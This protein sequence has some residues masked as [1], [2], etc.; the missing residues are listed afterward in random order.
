MSPWP[1]RTLRALGILQMVFAILGLW[2]NASGIISLLSSVQT[3]PRQPYFWHAYCAMSA[4]CVTCYVTLLVIAVEFIRLRPRLAPLFV[5]IMVFEVVYFFGIGVFWTSPRLGMSIEAA[6]GV[7]NGG[8]M[9][10]F[11]ALF[12]LW[13]SLLALWSRRRIEE[14]PMSPWELRFPSEQIARPSDWVYAGV[15][16]VVMFFLVSMVV[17]FAWRQMRPGTFTPGYVRVGV[18]AVISVVNALLAVRQRRRKRRRRIE[19]RHAAR[20]GAGLC[21]R[22]EYNLTGLPEP[23]CPECGAAFDARALGV[24]PGRSSSANQQGA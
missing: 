6:F 8:L 9:F 14:G 3:L 5:G 7:A 12:P 24:S 4:I 13:G 16:F 2:Y 18:P 10:Q 22:C 15:N 17:G 21:P 19:Q 11:I 1:H 20:L 23:R